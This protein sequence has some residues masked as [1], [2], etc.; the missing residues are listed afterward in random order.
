MLGILY[1]A[2]P[3]AQGFPINFL[4]VATL[5]SRWLTPNKQDKRKCAFHITSGQFF[6]FGQVVVFLHF[7]GSPKNFSRPEKMGFFQISR[8]PKSFHLA[9]AKGTCR[10]SGLERTERESKQYKH[11]EDC[12]QTIYLSVEKSS[13][14]YSKKLNKAGLDFSI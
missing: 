1:Q 5:F 9:W 6:H 4:K 11:D 13:T 2:E 14:G 3:F 12:F 10:L 8:M 7:V